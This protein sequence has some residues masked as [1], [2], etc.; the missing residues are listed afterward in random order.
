MERDNLSSSVWHNASEIFYSSIAGKGYHFP[1]NTRDTNK[2]GHLPD[3][4]M[5]TGCIKIV[6][7]ASLC[8]SYL[9]FM[10]L[11]L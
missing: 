3:I 9:H 11:E 5:H 1:G 2:K 6:S 4:P 8:K 7:T 10:F